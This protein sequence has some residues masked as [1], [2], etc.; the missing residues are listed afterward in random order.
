[1]R[2]LRVAKIH[3]VVHAVLLLAV[4]LVLVP[5]KVAGMAYFTVALLLGVGMLVMTVRGFL[6]GA[7]HRWARQVFAASLIYL[8][9][10]FAALALDA[11]V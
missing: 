1:M 7:G 10:L 9:V 5:L 2:G 8:P 11:M 6:P 4:S 3:A